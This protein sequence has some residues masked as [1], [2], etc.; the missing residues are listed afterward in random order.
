M[1]LFFQIHHFLHQLLVLGLDRGVEREGGGE[2][3]EF[4]PIQL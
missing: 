1:I 3:V 4:H 2:G